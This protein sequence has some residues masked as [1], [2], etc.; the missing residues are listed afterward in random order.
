[1]ASLVD[2][3]CQNFQPAGKASPRGK[4][5]RKGFS[6]RKI[7]ISLITGQNVKS[8]GFVI[9]AS[10]LL[11]SNYFHLFQGRIWVCASSSPSSLQSRWD[12][13]GSQCGPWC[14]VRSVSRSSPVHSVSSSDKQSTATNGGNT[15]S[16]WGQLRYVLIFG[17]L[18]YGLAFG[19][20]ITAID[21]LTNGSF[22]FR[23]AVLKLM[24]DAVLFGG[25]QG[26]WTW[27]E[28][29]YPVPFPPKYPPTK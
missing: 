5:R 22:H 6:W 3:D 10:R 13:L 26:A 25:F 24:F 17:V 27:T 29:R 14:F 28:F 8:P 19:L 2:G 4:P 18:G 11:F 1:M 15:S 20:V 16:S 21:F 12:L 9:H 7:A 23:S